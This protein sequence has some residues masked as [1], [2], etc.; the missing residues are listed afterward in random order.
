[1]GVSRRATTKDGTVLGERLRKNLSVGA[2]LHGK[3]P[4]NSVKRGGKEKN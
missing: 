3:L 2:S 1:M 4:N